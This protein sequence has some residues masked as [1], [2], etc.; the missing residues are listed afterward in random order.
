MIQRMKESVESYC[1][2]RN[3]LIGKI[4]RQKSICKEEELCKEKHLSLENEYKTRNT[5]GTCSRTTTAFLKSISD[6]FY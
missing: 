1:F 3:Q 6:S 5:P 4:G 2:E